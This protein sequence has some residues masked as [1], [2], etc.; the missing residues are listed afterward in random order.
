MFYTEYKN[1]FIYDQI[2]IQRQHFQYQTIPITYLKANKY[3]KKSPWARGCQEILTVKSRCLIIKRD[4]Y[5]KSF[6]LID[7][8]I[9]L[10][11]QLQKFFIIISSHYGMKILA[12]CFYIDVLIEYF[13]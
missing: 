8:N 12:F 2:F 5:L 11:V 9:Y 13:L 3:N 6:K 10:E 1:N 7:K 4:H